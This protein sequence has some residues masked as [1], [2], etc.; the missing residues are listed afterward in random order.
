[1]AKAMSEAEAL[2]RQQMYIDG[3]WTDSA[4]GEFFESFD[5]YTA[6]PWTLVPRANAEDVDRA[7]QAAQRAF[8]SGDWPKMHASQRGQLLRKLGDL[9]ARDAEELAEQG[10]I[11]FL[12]HHM[13]HAA[14]GVFGSEFEEGAYITL[15]G[16]GDEGQNVDSTW[17]VFEGTEVTQLG[18]SGH[19]SGLTA[20]HN[21]ICESVGF[22]SHIDNGKVM[23]DGKKEDVLEALKRGHIRRAS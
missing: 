4:S 23:A 9:I 1:M 18:D 2:P 20:F 17:G 10:R 16:G 14:L 8:T 6:K 15:D 13:S 7:V 21:Y 12:D 19:N 3:E 5:P 22:L 11:H